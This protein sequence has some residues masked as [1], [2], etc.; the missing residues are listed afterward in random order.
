MPSN[1][2]ITPRHGAWHG[3]HSM[4][5]GD[6]SGTMPYPQLKHISLYFAFAALCRDGRQAGRLGLTEKQA[7]KEAALLPAPSHHLLL[8]LPALPSNN[9]YPT[10]WYGR[11]ET[12][13]PPQV[14]M[15]FGGAPGQGGK[16]RHYKLKGRACLHTPRLSCFPRAALPGT[17]GG[18]Q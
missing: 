18:W 17:L 16:G 3:L 8:L 9:Y 1:E 13:L 5:E 7:N 2:K 12:G 15:D 6:S 10:L 4:R 11:R 14:D